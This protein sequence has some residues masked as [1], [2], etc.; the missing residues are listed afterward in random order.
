MQ[1]FSSISYPSPREK[2]AY[3]DA[4]LLNGSCFT[5]HIGNALQQSKFNVLQNPNGILFDA[6]QVAQSVIDW[7]EN[8]DF[9][10]QAF[11]MHNDWWQNWRL[12]SRFSHLD[13]DTAIRQ[14]NEAKNQAHHFLKQTN[15]LIL[16]LGSS[17]TYKINNQMPSEY[18]GDLCIGDGVAN[19]HKLPGKYFD[20]HLAG[21]DEMITALDTMFYRLVQFNPTI[22]VLFTVSP[23]RHLRDGVIENNRSKARLIE[24]VHHLVNK[25]DHIYYFP[26]YELVIDVLRDYRFYDVD[27]A[28]PNYAA[29]QYVINYFKEHCL[30]SDALAL[31]EKIAEIVTAK[32][33]KPRNAQSAAHKQFLE[34]Y[35][36]LVAEITA[37]N[38]YLDF[39]AERAYFLGQ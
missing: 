29:T 17:F 20:K 14:A 10:P 7:I 12:H 11:F 30:A 26:A 28:H 8:K 19:C 22:K 39:S 18:L 21:I 16:T 31:Q 38:P 34:K 4:L 15:W 27:L 2:I 3:T 24:T 23:V 13:I 1:F 35:A 32:N 25:F 5:E 9:Q 6:I 37:A 33:H 36:N